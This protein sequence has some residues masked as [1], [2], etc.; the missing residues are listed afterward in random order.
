M[1]NQLQTKADSDTGEVFQTAI[2][3]RPKSHEI[4]HFYLREIQEDMYDFECHCRSGGRR[5]ESLE[6]KRF[7]PQKDL[8]KYT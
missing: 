3:G 6:I 4:K 7:S 5:A 2:L 8:G 1:V